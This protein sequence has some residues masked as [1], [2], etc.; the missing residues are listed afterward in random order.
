MPITQQ[1][2]GRET[3]LEFQVD[4]TVTADV[5]G[6][7]GLHALAS[8]ALIGMIE[9]TAMQ[10]VADLL[11]PDERTV[12]SVIEVEHLAP[13]PVGATVEVRTRIDGVEGPKVWFTVEAQDDAAVIAR[14]RHARFVVDDERFRRRLDREIPA[15]TVEAHSHSASEGGGT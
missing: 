5:F 15:R 11:T 2:V 10:G 8:P 7:D 13:T 14:G 6:N 9:R 3:V 1:A 12:G 4:Y